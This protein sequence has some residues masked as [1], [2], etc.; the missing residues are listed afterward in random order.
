MKT[1]LTE[2]QAELF[3]VA[4]EGS[5]HNMAL[6][7]HVIATAL[8]EHPDDNNILCGIPIPTERSQMKAALA[9]VSKSVPFFAVVHEA[10]TAPFVPGDNRPPSQREDR[11][12]C[13]FAL[14]FVGGKMVAAEACD[15]IRGTGEVFFK[16][17]VGNGA[18][19]ESFVPVEG[20]RFA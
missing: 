13:L 19:G 4:K 15:V 3:R 2:R 1:Q 11:R 18:H 9:T 7:G 8:F 20:G 17:W 10:W 6:S 12:E 5:Q 14:L 16:P